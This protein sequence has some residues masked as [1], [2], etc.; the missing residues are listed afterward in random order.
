MRTTTGRLA[1]LGA[2]TVLALA[3]CNGGAELD[4]PEVDQ[5]ELDAE[6]E[7]DP[8]PDEPET[9][10]DPD[11]DADGDPPAAEEPDD[12]AAAPDPEETG[13]QA[14]PLEGE[15]GTELVQDDGDWGETLAV[16]DVR[17]GSH[18]GF[19][20]VV[21]ELEGDGQA[22]WFVEYGEPRAH[23]SGDEVEVAGDAVLNVALSNLTLP[24]ELPDDID[25][26]FQQSLDGPAGGIVVEVR[27]DTIFEGMHLFF[28]GIDG[29]E[30]PFLVERFDD[31]QRVVIDLF[32]D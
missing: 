32:H 20:R 14:Q 22:G 25:H 8:E 19:D 29:D 5:P 23:G 2:A 9:E 28:V 18:T 11:A 15:P 3:A 31:P 16:T 24:P 4:Q 21:F 17:V 1:A 10:T 27:D 12:E 13:P 26:W 6:P 7:P 30:R